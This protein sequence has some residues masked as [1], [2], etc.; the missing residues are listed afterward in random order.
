MVFNTVSYYNNY[1]RICRA[2]W[3]VGEI[4]AVSMYFNRAAVGA[5][6]FRDQHYIQF[7][8]SHQYLKFI[9]LGANPLMFQVAIGRPILIVH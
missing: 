5:L 8:F 7:L 1:L 3:V 6:Y 2:I 4:A 9:L